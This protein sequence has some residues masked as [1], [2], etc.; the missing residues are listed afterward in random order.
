MNKRIK[1]ETRFVVDT[2]VNRGWYMNKKYI[3][4]TQEN[5]DYLILSLM[6]LLISED[7]FRQRGEDHIIWAMMGIP[8][9][10]EILRPG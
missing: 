7:S 6:N 1:R 10:T 4:D 8:G 3:L 5:R 2:R 9:R